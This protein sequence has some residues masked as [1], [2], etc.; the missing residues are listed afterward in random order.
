MEVTMKLYDVYS[1]QDIEPVKALGC[2]VVD[3]KGE[4]YLDLYGGHA[5]I[6]VGHTHPTYVKRLTEQLNKIGFYSNAVINNVQADYAKKLGEFCDYEEYSLFM[7]NSGAEANE[8]ALKL[9]SFHT[10][11]DRVLA[12]KGAFHG[13]TSGTVAITDNPAIISPFN[14]TDKVTFVEIDDI[15]AVRKELASGEYCAV[16]I[17]GI[18]GVGGIVIPED[19]FL[20]ELEKECNKNGVCLILDEIQS[21]CGR[22]G[23]YFAHQHTGIKPDLIT[24]AKG[25]GNGFPMGALLISPK[26][27]AVKGSLGTTFG[28]NHLAA[29]AG[30]AIIEVMEEERLIENAAKVGDYLLSELKKINS[31]SIKEIRG[32]GLMIAIEMNMPVAELRNKILFEHK[33]FTGVAGKNNIRLLPP[34][35]LT[36]EQAKRFI[37]TFKTLV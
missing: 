31:D 10:G 27:E 3:S 17:E 37:D 19:E 23:R 36:K 20:R 13:R 7:C 28:G 16:I 14:Q 5:V 15:D 25:V 26:F 12:F 6:S 24:V 33:M 18:L 30:S 32:R 34:L 35:C 22:T 9:A 1:I 29:A 2:T 21:G 8:N 11:K 4:E